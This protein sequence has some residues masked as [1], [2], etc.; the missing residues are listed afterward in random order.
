MRKKEPFIMTEKIKL[1]PWHSSF[2]TEKVNHYEQK[3][4]QGI[5]ARDPLLSAP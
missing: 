1:L 4:D 5:W 2:R 3:I